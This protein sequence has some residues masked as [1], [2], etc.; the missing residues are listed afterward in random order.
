MPNESRWTQIVEILEIS[1]ITAN[2]KNLFVIKGEKKKIK[3]RIS[4]YLCTE[5]KK[6][7]KD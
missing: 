3:K 5:G 7:R 1:Q 6:E 2:K 4:Y